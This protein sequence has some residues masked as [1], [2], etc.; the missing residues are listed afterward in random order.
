MN[1]QQALGSNSNQQEATGNNMKQQE[2]TV[3]PKCGCV[4]RNFRPFR[5]FGV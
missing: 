5:L 2:A 3:Q 4:G 1:Q